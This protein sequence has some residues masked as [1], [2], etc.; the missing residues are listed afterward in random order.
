MKVQMVAA[1]RPVAAGLEREQSSRLGL[2]QLCI[3]A[4]AGLGELDEHGLRV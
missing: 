3:A 2:N 4:A 1:A